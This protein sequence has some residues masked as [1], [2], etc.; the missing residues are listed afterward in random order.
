MRVAAI[1]PEYGGDIEATESRLQP[2]VDEVVIVNNNIDNRLFTKAINEGI[3]QC[4]ADIYW[5]VNNDVLPDPH[6]VEA[7]VN[8]F[9]EQGIGQT[10]IV[11]S[12]NRLQSD[13]DYITWGGS[14]QAYPAGRHK[15]GRVSKGELQ[16]RTQETWITFA[17]AFVNANVI[18]DIGLLDENM[19][20]IGSDSDYCYR[21][22][23]AGYKCYH[24]P[25][26]IV[27]HE[28]GTSHSTSNQWLQSVMQADMLC[29]ERKW[30]YRC[31]D[32][33]ERTR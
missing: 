5:I 8:C 27:Y 15:S 7:A 21:A 10:G 24:E 19:R 4:N 22:R 33:I 12:Q 25:K 6:C 3:E 29:W 18:R 32:Q 28:P 2:L 1:V 14:Y 23:Q 11:G 30:V 20:H 9:V 16:Q 31:W 13:M 17:S 26:S